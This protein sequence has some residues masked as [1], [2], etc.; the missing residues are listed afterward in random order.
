MQATVPT[1]AFLVGAQRS[2]TTALASVLATH[3]DLAALVNGKVAYLLIAWLLQQPT[4][5][6]ARHPRLDEVAHAFLRRKPLNLDDSLCTRIATYL[7]GTEAARHLQASAR[8]GVR[9]GINLICGDVARLVN[10]NHLCH[11]DKYNEYLLQLTE[12]DEIFPN[13]RYLFVHRDPHDVA[14]SMVRHFAGRSWAPVD[15]H[16]AFEKWVKWN[17]LWLDH[18]SRISVRRFHEVCYERL[19][20]APALVIREILEFLELDASRDWIWAASR[21]IRADAVGRGAHLARSLF[22]SGTPLA[23]ECLDV[24]SRVDAVRDALST[25]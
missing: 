15:H 7:E 20:R 3:P 8:G 18:R 1:T 4:H 19:V 22:A 11:L 25:A 6:E 21:R 10:R 2:G 13:A 9:N 23:Q 12:L 14:E 17:T 24:Q 5:I 16:A